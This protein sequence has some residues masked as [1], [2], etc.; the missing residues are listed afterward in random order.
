MNAN[1]KHQHKK[2]TAVARRC[3]TMQSS[4][5]GKIYIPCILADGVLFRYIPQAMTL[6]RAE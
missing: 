3:T 5:L 6:D 1:A 2:L 4:D